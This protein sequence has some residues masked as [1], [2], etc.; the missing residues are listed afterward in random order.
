MNLKTERGQMG[1]ALVAETYRQAGYA[2]LRQ[3]YR[4]R[5]GEVDLIVEKN[6]LL[7]F[8]EVKTRS[9]GN[10]GSAAEAVTPHKQRRLL[11]AAQGYLAQH[12]LSDPMMRFDVAEVLLL[13]DGPQVNIIEDAFQA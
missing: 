1:E 3:N 7:V 9:P 13:P 5:Q 10:Y 11:L 2:L 6:G 4:T 12:G 8:C